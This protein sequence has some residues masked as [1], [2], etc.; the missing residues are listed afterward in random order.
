MIP[1]HLKSIAARM[2]A[3]QATAP[4]KKQR[5]TLLDRAA[6]IG[7]SVPTLRSWQRGGC[8][9][10]DDAEVRNRIARATKLPP[11][12]KPEW[13]PA[14]TGETLGEAR[15][16]LAIAQANRAEVLAAQAKKE[17]VSK[18]MVEEALMRIAAAV[19]A[20][21]RRMEADLP[22]MLEGADPAA[23]QRIIREKVDQVM[24]TLSDATAEVW[25]ADDAGD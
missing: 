17:Y 14:T 13:Q 7:C 21:V 2:A 1:D 6:E 8:N 16:R 19:K 3:E 10:F 5:K 25:R 22:P 15:R 11:G 18:A 12:I 23:M 24:T 4:P 9:V 20:A